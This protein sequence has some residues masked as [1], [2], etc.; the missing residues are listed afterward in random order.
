MSTVEATTPDGDGQLK[1]SNSREYRARYMDQEN[2][3]SWSVGCSDGR[4]KLEC[5]GREGDHGV[6]VPKMVR[7][8]CALHEKR[9]H[10]QFFPVRVR[11]P[12]QY[13]WTPRT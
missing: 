3:Q 7:G 1:S 9:V 10:V 11:L 8:K 4:Q 5:R 6:R 13:T 12:A 2:S